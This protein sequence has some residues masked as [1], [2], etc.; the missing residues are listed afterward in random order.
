MS[1]HVDRIKAAAF[2]D[3][4]AAYVAVVQGVVDAHFK[5]CYPN[6]TA[7]R[8]TIDPKGRKFVRIVRSDDSGSR[9][10]HSFVERATG[11]VLKAAGWKAPAKHS[12][13]N[14]WAPDTGRGAIDSTGF[15]V[16]LR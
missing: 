7:P 16:Y 2:G 11:N 3:R 6:L 12:R 10:V 9:S 13:G 1:E 14:I 5:A 4:L 8:F 15:T